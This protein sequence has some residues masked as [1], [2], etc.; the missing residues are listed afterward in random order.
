MFQTDLLVVSC[1]LVTTLPLHRLADLHRTYDASLTILLSQ[2]PEL[3]K[4]S[5]PGGKASK[6]I[7]QKC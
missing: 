7:G 2:T 1:D 4:S 5:A 3:A 6:K